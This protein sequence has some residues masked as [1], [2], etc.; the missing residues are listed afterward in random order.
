MNSKDVLNKILTLLSVT[1]ESDVQLTYARLADGTIVESNTFDVGEPIEVV[2]EDGTKTPAPDGEHELVLKGA[3]GEEV[4]FKVIVKDGKIEEREN[5]ELGDKMPELPTEG[6]SPTGPQTQLAATT[7]EAHPLPMTTD[8]DPRNTIADDS[9]DTEKDPLITLSYRIAELEKAMDEMKTKME[10]IT[11]E[12]EKKAAEVKKEE[13]VKMEEV[14]L[15]K[16]D[17]APID[18]VNLSSMVANKANKNKIGNT[19]NSFLSKLYN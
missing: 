11:P 1:K 9:E 10:A 8:E 6:Q 14:E 2:S 17:G 18:T 4:R 13:D 3:E 19:Q 5:V 7:E 15:P 16:L 12:E